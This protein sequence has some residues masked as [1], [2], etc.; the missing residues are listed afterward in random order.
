LTLVEDSKLRA[1][2]LIRRIG[3]KRASLRALARGSAGGK[4]LP[5][6]CF[7]FR[8]VA[9]SAGASLGRRTGQ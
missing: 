3:I 7:A 5:L 6:L 4:V 1:M 9:R 2:L 8:L